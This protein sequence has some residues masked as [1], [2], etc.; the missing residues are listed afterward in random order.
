MLAQEQRDAIRHVLQT[1]PGLYFAIL[2]G[3]AA[4]GGPFRDV[5]IGLFVDR[6]TITPD[7]D[8]VVCFDLERR[9]RRVVP[10][11]VDVRVINEAS[12]A[13]RY[14]VSKG[15]PLLVNDD[16]VYTRFLEYTWDRYLDFAPVAMAYVRAIV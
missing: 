3:S 11:P 14:N 7:D 5:D 9:L 2:Y 12:L 6:Q 13:F 1:I 10:F 15:A 4:R 16:D 8:F